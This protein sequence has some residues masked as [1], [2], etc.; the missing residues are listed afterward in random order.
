ML[1]LQGRCSS[2]ST[3]RFMCSSSSPSSAACWGARAVEEALPRTAGPPGPRLRLLLL[4]PDSRS[5][6]ISKIQLATSWTFPRLSEEENGLAFCK[7][8]QKGTKDTDY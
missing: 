8:T 3:T 7:E 6:F 2:S 1:S 4:P 5:W